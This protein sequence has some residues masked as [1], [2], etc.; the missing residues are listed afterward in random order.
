MVLFLLT[1]YNLSHLCTPTGESIQIEA[2]GVHKAWCLEHKPVL[3]SLLIELRSAAKKTNKKNRMLKKVAT[4][5]ISTATPP[6]IDFPLDNILLPDHVAL[7]YS[8][9]Q[10]AKG[11]R[12]SSKGVV[13]IRLIASL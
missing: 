10:I 1:D 4:T 3:S 12:D 2:I 13:F 5:I 9:A 11:I 6:P 7:L 8:S